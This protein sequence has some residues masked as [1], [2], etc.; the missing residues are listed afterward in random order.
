MLRTLP[1]LFL[2]AAAG[3]ACPEAAA[4]D[5]LAA[6]VLA[7]TP[8]TAIMQGASMEDALCAQGMLVERLS[9]EM[10]P[11][12]GYKAGLT[13][14]AVQERFGVSS[15]VR[16]VLLEGMMLEDGASVPAAFG[17]RPIFEADLILVVGDAA[18][19]EATTPEEVLAS[20][21][22]VRPFIELADLV[23]A[24]GEPLDGAVITAI[25]VG[26][27]MG[28]MGE[29]IPASEVTVEDLATVTVRLEA[30][31]E[32]VS[33]APG[34][35]VLGNPLNAVLFLTGEGIE[36]VEGDLISVGSMGPPA[37]PRAGITA[38]ATYLGLPGDP[39]VSVTFE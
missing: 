33:E 23:V 30:G 20:L 7:G 11:P 34:A 29:G 28:A 24:E 10:G 38:T 21:S 17:A 14:A 22:E 15:P 8:A 4:V 16:G 25:N 27:R 36:L 37:P 18:I 12:V 31:G 35:A 6:D 19:N 2:P 3:A 13:S 32:V 26:A 9:A 5:A 39:A 1:F